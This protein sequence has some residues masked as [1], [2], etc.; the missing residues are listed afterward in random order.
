[1]ERYYDALDKYRPSD[2]IVISHTRTAADHIRE[3]I[4]DPESIKKYHKKQE[5]AKKAGIVNSKGT[6]KKNIDLDEAVKAA[7]KAQEI[8]GES[9]IAIRQNLLNEI[10]EKTGKSKK[11][12]R[13]N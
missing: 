1:M 2:I 8:W 6:L 11:S 9:D 10:A 13:N 7:Q 4:N 3:K 12:S 5:W